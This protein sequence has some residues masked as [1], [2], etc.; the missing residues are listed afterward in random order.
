MGPTGSYR[1]KILLISID[2]KDKRGAFRFR[3]KESDQK[4]R[5]VRGHRVHP[6]LDRDNNE[7]EDQRFGVR[8]QPEGIQPQGC[9]L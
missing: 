6:Q 8:D 7:S 1:P 9:C 4:I 3:E 5:R 2:G